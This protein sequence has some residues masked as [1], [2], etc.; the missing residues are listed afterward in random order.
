MIAKKSPEEIQSAIDLIKDLP[1]VPAWMLDANN[2][3]S[4]APL[5]QEELYEFA[6]FHTKQLRINAA[7]HY[8]NSCDD[9]FGRKEN[10]Q[11]VFR[12]PGVVIEIDQNVIET[13][14]IHQVE[15]YV[16]EEKPEEKYLA[17]MRFYMG[18]EVARKEHG[19]TWLIDFI[20]SVFIE[21]ANEFKNLFD[22]CGSTIH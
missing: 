18:D 9:R 4:G 21:G 2:Y 15:R 22:N 14:L 13:L 16:M 6:E 8:L 17:P 11:Q 12:A 1:G 5:T 10:G 7:L 20:D 3:G 19:S